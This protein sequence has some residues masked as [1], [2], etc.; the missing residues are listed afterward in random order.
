MAPYKK[1]LYDKAAEE[2]RR[3]ITWLRP[4]VI[5]G[6]RRS[7]TKDELLQAAMAEL[8]VS[9]N[10]FEHAWVVVIEETGRHDWYTANRPRK[11]TKQ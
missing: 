10:S 7:F 6:Q 1:A 9:K 11:Q 4:F 2:R 8:K 3:C 5:D